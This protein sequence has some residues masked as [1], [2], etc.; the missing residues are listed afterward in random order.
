MMISSYRDQSWPV[1]RVQNPLT[2][3]FGPSYSISNSDIFISQIKTISEYMHHV[4]M[5]YTLRRNISK[6]QS[7]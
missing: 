6:L 5:R 1:F 4:C 2:E 7:R 3:D